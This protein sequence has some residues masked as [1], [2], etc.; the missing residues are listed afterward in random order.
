MASN[1]VGREEVFDGYIN[2]YGSSFVA[3]QT[4]ELVAE[5]PYVPDFV[6]PVDG[7]ALGGTGGSEE[8]GGSGRGGEVAMHTFDL[9]SIRLQRAGWGLFRDRRPALYRPLLTLDGRV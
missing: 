9:E 5:C 6:L 2:F 8:G 4:G 1:R 3:D 7:S